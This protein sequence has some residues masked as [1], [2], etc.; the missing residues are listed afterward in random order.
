MG[1]ILVCVDLA[2]ELY[3]QFGHCG[4]SANAKS[5]ATENS[6]SGGRSG[7]VSGGDAIDDGTCD[8]DGEGAAPAF[9]TPGSESKQA[10]ADDEIGNTVS[11]AVGLKRG[12]S[13]D[14]SNSSNG[15]TPLSQQQ[16]TVVLAGALERILFAFTMGLAALAL[17]AALWA[18][19]ILSL[20]GRIVRWMSVS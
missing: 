20:T 14:E 9:E 4:S 18:V 13:K 11:S 19:S 3:Y 1:F 12:D 5:A 16:K 7:G 6:S 8:A 17:S 15:F 10:D 2:G